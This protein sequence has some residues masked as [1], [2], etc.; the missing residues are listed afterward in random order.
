MRATPS[1]VTIVTMTSKCT[2][3]VRSLIV[4]EIQDADTQVIDR[5]GAG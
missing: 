3:N 4:E 5:W 1:V 2:T